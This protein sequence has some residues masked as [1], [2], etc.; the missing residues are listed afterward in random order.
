MPEIGAVL[1]DR[2][3]LQ[4][5]LSDNPVRE[6]W[7][8]T[9]LTNEERVVVKLLVFG[10]QKQWDNLKL[11]DREAKVLQNLQHPQI[12][13]YRDYF[14]IDDRL[15]WSGLVQDY[16]PGSSLLQQLDA[17]KKYTEEE[18]RDIATALLEILTYLHELSPPVLHRDIKPSNIIL[19]E[20]AKV[21]LVDFGA[22]QDQGAVAGRSFTVVGTYG[23]TPLEQFGGQTVP[24][25][26]LYALGATLV[27]L[28]T[29][30]PPGELLAEDLHLQFQDRLST[31]L[32]PYFIPWLEKLTEPQLSQRF[33]SAKEALSA[34]QSGAL[35]PITSPFFSRMLP[36]LN[37]EKTSENWKLSSRS[38]AANYWKL[39]SSFSRNW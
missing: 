1:H 8:A 34:L 7:L 22:V 37:S 23:Y 4:S 35:S 11:F 25:S 31:N 10:G 5:L 18:V 16:I 2:Y 12:P 38:P 29:G 20:D 6:T 33:R 28:L 19:G 32:S 24:A 9:D 14:T 15:L 30:V 3:Q 39:A 17:G 13:R 36:K 21:Y 27:H 26:D